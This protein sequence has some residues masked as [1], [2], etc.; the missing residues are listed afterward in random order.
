[1]HYLDR[2]YGQFEIEEPVIIELIN[3]PT[4]QRL[5][6]IDQSGYF[7]VHFPGTKHSRFE[8]SLG[9][10]LLLKMFEAPLE[11]QIAGLIHDV[12]HSAFSHC[13]DY[14]LAGGSQIRQS[15]QDNIFAEFV[16]QSEIPSILN[17]H[18]FNLAYIL[19]DKNFPLKETELPDLCA[20]RID[21]S[22]RT[23]V[24]FG[25]VDNIDNYLTALT[26]DHSRWIFKDFKNAKLYAEL[27][28]KLNTIYY[29][30]LA[31][32]VMFRSVGDLLCH[33]LERGY[34]TKTDLYTTDHEVLQ[35]ITNELKYDSQLQLL[36]DRMNGKKHSFN[37]PNNYEATVFCKS[38]VVDP[39]C[40]HEGAVRKV[41]AVEPVWKE[42]IKRETS[43][44]QYFL[45]FAK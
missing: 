33:S 8:H 42:I 24:V 41:S 30:G 25:E 35:K 36:F 11:E 31:S 21:Y 16:R 23:A 29:A 12:S 14:V 2:I 22:L 3:S 27:F 5:K 38:R 19:D 26:V 28:L 1:M 45:R 44:K 18:G 32:A 9:V 13:I 37:D 7:E 39:L 15:H 6:G 20:D 43:P 34:V 40:W 4:L 17:K 10:Y